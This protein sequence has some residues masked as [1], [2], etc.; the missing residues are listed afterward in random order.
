MVLGLNVYFYSEHTYLVASWLTKATDPPPGQYNVLLII[1]KIDCTLAHY[2]H[3]KMTGASSLKQSDS[4]NPSLLYLLEI[5]WSVLV[6]SQLAPY[7]STYYWHL[8]I[9]MET[10]DKK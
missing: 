8:R 5:C 4:K 9:S 3:L 6:P 10:G 7:A 1:T 2:C